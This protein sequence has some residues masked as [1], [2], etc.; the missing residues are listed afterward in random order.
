MPPSLSM[1]VPDVVVAAFLVVFPE[2]PFF[3]FIC[4]LSYNMEAR[5]VALFI[6]TLYNMKPNRRLVRIVD[7]Q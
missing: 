5:G 1:R 3:F 2:A 7:L 6:L 4:L